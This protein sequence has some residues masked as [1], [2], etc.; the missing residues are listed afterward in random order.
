MELLGSFSARSQNSPCVL[1]ST[2]AKRF[3]IQ[4]KA[5]RGGRRGTLSEASV[6]RFKRRKQ[7]S[8]RPYVFPSS[9][10]NQRND[11]AAAT[12]MMISF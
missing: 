6:R 5:L 3:S 4:Y 10:N 12:T 9:A 1:C 7:A 2:C 8:V 11:H